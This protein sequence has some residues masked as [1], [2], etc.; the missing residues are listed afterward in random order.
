MSQRV[1]IAPDKFKGTLSAAAAASAIARGW[2]S[3][4]PGDTLELLPMSD[5]GDGFGEVLST[6][7][8]SRERSVKTF[9]A[10]RQPC[11]PV[12]WFEPETSTAV[13]EEPRETPSAD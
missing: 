8:L 2:R 4:R 1:L 10:A 9:D 3:V 5:G 11:E 7:H 6:L 13:A 12:W